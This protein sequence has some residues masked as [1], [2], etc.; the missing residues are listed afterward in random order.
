MM[1]KFIIDTIMLFYYINTSE[2]TG[3]L[4]RVGMISSYVKITLFFT[5]VIRSPL[6]WL[7]NPL[8]ST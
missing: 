8:K 5:E 1:E 3:E 7:H 2:I 6:L 4:S